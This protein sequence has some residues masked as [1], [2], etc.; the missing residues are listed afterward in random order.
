MHTYDKD[1]A[2]VDLAK[3]PSVLTPPPGPKS[4]AVAERAGEYMK[5]Y[6]SQAKL[7]PVA[8][9]SGKGV[10]LT[11]V[12]GN[13]YIDFSGGIYI[14]N[15][16][17]CHPKITEAVV[18]QTRKL[19]NCHDF[20]TEIKTRLLEKLADITPGDLNGIQLWCNGS[21]A[22][23]AGMNIARAATGKFEF[24]SF[25]NDFHGKTLGAQS[26]TH[27]SRVQGVR[28]A[29]CYRVPYGN[30]YHCSFKLEYPSC[31]L[32][33]VDYIREVIEQQTTQ[34]VA[35][36]VLEPIQGW[37]GSVVPPEGYL[38]KMR[39]LC[40]E[41][42]ILL[43][44][45]EVLTCMG[46][47]GKPFAVEHWGVIPDILTLGKGLGNGFPVT[48]TVFSDKFKDRMEGVSASSSYGGNPVACA[49][50][51][52]SIEVLEEEGLLEHAAELGE[53]ILGRLVEIQARHTIVGQVRGKGCL[54][55]MEI[56]KDRHTREPFVEAGTMIYQEAFKRGLAWI[57]AK[58]NLRMSPPLIMPEAVAA[59]ALEIIEEAIDETECALG[60]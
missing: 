55:G 45:D 53:F 44:A 48:A 2:A 13:T 22:V 3:V 4:L 58:Q 7:F 42:G 32:H 30:C 51:L 8:F 21:K 57:P 39:T 6:S 17:H 47:T 28:A 9:E 40:D 5:G 56:V 24:I 33:C 29:G 10:T 27:M 1:W 46:R 38:Q 25:H 19:Q 35:A 18:S 50:A 12:D 15:F 60:Y 59:K 54:L 37:G 14:T 43:F 26:L 36:I 23:E 34:E 16:G 52:A 20:N 41:C 49:A 11:D 31:G